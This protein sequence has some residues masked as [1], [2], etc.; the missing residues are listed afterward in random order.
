M[1][2][3]FTVFLLGAMTMGAI[4]WAVDFGKHPHLHHAHEAIEHAKKQLA[5]ANDHKKTE[6]GG[7]RSSA[8]GHLN[9]AQKEVEAAVEYAN[10]NAK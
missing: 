6:F 3:K 10:S 7:H 4:A 2:E 8:I 9:E 1:K 5:E